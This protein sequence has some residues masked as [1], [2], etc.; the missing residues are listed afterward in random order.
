MPVWETGRMDRE[1]LG[2]VACFAPATWT[3]KTNA[4]DICHEVPRA[5]TARVIQLGRNEGD[6][7][8]SSEERR[9]FGWNEPQVMQS[10]MSRGGLQVVAGQTLVGIRLASS[11]ALAPKKATREGRGSPRRPWPAR[12]RRRAARPRPSRARA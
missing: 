7:E 9:D 2:G 3:R 12:A 4:H 8:G 6:A 5:R 1:E 11:R 10:A